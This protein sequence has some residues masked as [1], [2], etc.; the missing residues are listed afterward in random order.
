MSVSIILQEK[1]LLTISLSMT[2][3]TWRVPN[4]VHNGEKKDKGL[5]EAALCLKRND[6]MVKG[7][8]C[9]VTGQG[10]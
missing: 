6:F 10:Y 3:Q 4:N 2:I 9:L 7:V 5:L 1:R 8:F